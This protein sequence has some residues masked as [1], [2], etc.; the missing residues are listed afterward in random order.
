MLQTNEK[1][2][3]YR[4]YELADL[5][6]LAQENSILWNHVP[7][8]PIYLIDNWPVKSVVISPDGRYV[9]IAGKRGLAHYS[10]NSGRWKTFVNE[11][12]EHSFHVRGGMCWYHHILIAAVECDGVYEVSLPWVC[13]VYDYSDNGQIRLYSRETDLDN[14]HLLH[15][16]TLPAPIVLISLVGYDSLLAYTLDNILYHYVITPTK[17]TVKLIQV[18]QLTFHGIIRSPSRVRGLSWILPEEQILEGDPARDVTV[19]SVLFLV[20]GK[21]ALLQPG[22]GEGGEVK[23]EMRVLEKNVEYYCLMRDQPLQFVQSE[24]TGNHT[25]IEMLPSGNGRIK[26]GLRDSLWIFDGKDLKAWVDVLEVMQSARR[27]SRELPTTIKVGVDF[28][29]MSILLSKGIILGIESELV[30]RRDINF[31]YLKF[32][33]RVGPRLPVN[34]CHQTNH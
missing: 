5:T 10:I 21:L 17:D 15:I 6:T 27:G 29:P 3:I 34:S 1:L 11:K 22:S 32:S 16:E 30:Q 23:Y 12:M 9:A 33:T 25:P 7:M 28:Y 4:G 26:E 24:A 19:A 13:V 20:D 14:T 31:S 8:P 2:L 18:G